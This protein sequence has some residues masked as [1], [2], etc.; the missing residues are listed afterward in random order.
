MSAAKQ[1]IAK[2]FDVTGLN[3]ALRGLQSALASPH[4]RAINYHEVPGEEAGAFEAQLRFYEKHFHFMGLADLIALSAG[5]WPHAKP[6]L[7]L[8]FDD[9]LDS[10]A[11]VVAPLLEKVG[12][13]GWFMVPAAVLDDGGGGPCEQHTVEQ[14]TMS[15][16]QLRRL[17]ERH[18][19]GCHT[20]S[21]RRLEASLSADE[22]HHEIH[23]SRRLL[24]EGLG[25]PIDVFTWVG[26]EEWTYS[27]KAAQVIR[28]EGFQV[29]F[30]TNSLPFRPGDDLLQVQRTNIESSFDPALVGL[31]LSGFFDVLYAAKRRRVNRLTA[32]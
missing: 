1:L 8:T 29:S 7:I 12:A 4:A 24:E 22:L 3:R 32:G 15:W 20:Y 25:H 19:I 28:D 23:D 17:D 16:E 31:S 26:G 2:T 13:S 11:S 5:D 27:E 9:G 10:H 14:K 6:G 21:H 18:V 30:M